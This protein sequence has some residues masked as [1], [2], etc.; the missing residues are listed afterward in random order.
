MSSGSPS[1]SAL[2]PTQQEVDDFVAAAGK[3]DLGVVAAFLYQYATIINSPVNFPSS[4]GAT[5]L[6]FAA[7]QGEMGIVD[8]LLLRGAA[9]YQCESSG[10]TPLIAA[11]IGGHKDI[12]D[13]LL[14]NG[15]DI[16]GKGR[17]GWTPVMWAAYEG[18]TEIAR[19]LLEKGAAI[20]YEDENRITAEML[21][22]WGG[23]KDTM[24]FFAQ[25]MK[26]QNTAQEPEG[27]VPTV[28]NI[29]VAHLEKLKS[30]RPSQSPFKRK[31]PRP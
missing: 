4:G 12:V 3:P 28:K 24:E 29:A 14:Q 25:W 2:T 13:M 26:R 20:D 15:A 9:V 1:N 23:H 10:K 27:T 17:S 6:T 5:A 11:I 30:Q 7:A 22:G 19:F 21:A 16:D 18:K 31:K 8:L